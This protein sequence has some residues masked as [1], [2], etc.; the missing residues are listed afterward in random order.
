MAAL[1]AAI[2]N[3]RPVSTITRSTVHSTDGDQD[4]LVR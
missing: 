1:T 2:T 4:R 3:P